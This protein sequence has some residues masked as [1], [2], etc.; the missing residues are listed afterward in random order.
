M[1]NVNATI[2]QSQQLALA[3]MMSKVENLD[4][5][6]SEAILKKYPIKT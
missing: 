3:F 4:Q 2:I 1:K 6:V 5:F